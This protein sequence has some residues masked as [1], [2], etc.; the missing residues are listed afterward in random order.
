MNDLAFRHPLMGF[1]YYI[2]RAIHYLV[3]QIKGGFE[4]HTFAVFMN[5]MFF[6]PTLFIGPINR[7]EDFLPTAAAGAGTQTSSLTRIIYGYTKIV[8]IAYYLVNEKFA[9]WIY[10]AGIR[11]SCVIYLDCW[12][13]ALNLFP[14][15]GDLLRCRDRY[16]G[17]AGFSHQREF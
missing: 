13:Y 15:L 4:E 7:F 1:A 9:L 12:H 6:L 16:V 17:A 11:Q 10:I 2:L 3:E 14:V 5:Y 8:V